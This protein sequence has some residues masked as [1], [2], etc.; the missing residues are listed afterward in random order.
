MISFLYPLLY[1]LLATTNPPLS[2]PKINHNKRSEGSCLSGL[3][4]DPY[5]PQYDQEIH[6]NGDTIP[7]VRPPEPREAFGDSNF[8]DDEEHIYTEPNLTPASLPHTRLVN[9]RQNQTRPLIPTQYAHGYVTRPA[10]SRGRP[11]S[12]SQQPGASR[13]VGLGRPTS[14]RT[15]PAMPRYTPSP[16]RSSPPNRNVVSLP[17]RFSPLSIV[18]KLNIG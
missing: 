13:S 8:Y 6:V 3:G 1:I 7:S 10:V 12:A 2:V 15:D 11:T 14:A 5:I 16:L 17:V 4:L 9:P 18:F